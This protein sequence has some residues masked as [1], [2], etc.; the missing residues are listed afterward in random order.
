MSVGCGCKCV[1]AY[2]GRLA[3]SVAGHRG[4]VKKK[5]GVYLVKT[6]I[7]FELESFATS[8]ETTLGVSSC[9]KPSLPWG[10]RGKSDSEA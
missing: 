3:T 2:V 1:V 8:S 9:A 5:K 6:R 10:R 7:G 4:S